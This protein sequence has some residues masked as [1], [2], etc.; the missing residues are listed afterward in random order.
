ME[1]L[2]QILIKKIEIILYCKML[3]YINKI[4]WTIVI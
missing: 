1:K 2:V 3:Y 4:K